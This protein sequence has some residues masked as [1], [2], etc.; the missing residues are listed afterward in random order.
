MI[1]KNLDI[2]ALCEAKLSGKVGKFFET[3][4]GYKN[5]VGERV[6]AT[7]LTKRELVN[8]IA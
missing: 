3:N 1:K 7:I 2:V 6:E 4:L 5:S 8:C